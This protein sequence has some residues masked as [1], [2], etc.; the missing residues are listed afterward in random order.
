MI[1]GPCQWI[2]RTVINEIVV[3]VEDDTI[4]LVIHWQGGDHTSLKVKKNRAGRHRWSTEAQVVDLVRVLARQ[5]PDK[6]IAAVLNRAGK[7]T[8]RGNSWTRARVCI[9]RN[10]HS[11]EPYREGE[12]SSRGEV[13]LGEAA[14]ALKV[15]QA[16]VRRLIKE[17]V[18]PG[19]Q[20]CKGAP[21]VI[22]VSDLDR[23]DVKRAADARRHRRPASHNLLQKEMVL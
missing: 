21:W 3:R 20:L 10:R 15:S 11:I 1:A 4:A 5:M 23:D 18:L 2:I 6:S 13:T 16:T 17:G 22:L 19:Q 7:T 9:C 12:R 8:G 14:E